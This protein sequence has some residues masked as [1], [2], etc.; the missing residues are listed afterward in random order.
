MSKDPFIS[1]LAFSAM[2]F[3]TAPSALAEDLTG[4]LN[5]HEVRP[6][7]APDIRIPDSNPDSNAANE[8]VQS[9]VQELEATRAVIDHAKPPAVSL[10]VNGWVSEQVS[11]F[12]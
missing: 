11:K 6:A 10:S 1:A 8:D 12:K 9:R 4:D 3:A 7:Q 2:A 5:V